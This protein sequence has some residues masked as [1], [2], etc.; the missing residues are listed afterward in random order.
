M[1]LVVTGSRHWTDQGPIRG[2]LEG[3]LV[4]HP[5]LVV[6]VGDARGVDTVVWEVCRGLGVPVTR[7]RADWAAHGRAAGPMRNRAMLDAAE[8]DLVVAFPLGVSR[9]T[10]ECVRAARERGIEVMMIPDGV[11]GPPRTLW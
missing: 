4:D 10:M 5:G 11:D 6:H 7:Y 9:G 1:R 8:P 3:L 2:L